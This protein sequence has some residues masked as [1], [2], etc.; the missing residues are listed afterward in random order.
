MNHP[1][2]NAIRIVLETQCGCRR[3]VEWVPPLPVRIEVPLLRPITPALKSEPD[4]LSTP[5]LPVRIFEA[6]GMAEGLPRYRETG[7]GLAD[8]PE[9]PRLLREEWADAVSRFMALQNATF[10]EDWAKVR[11]DFH[12]R[13]DGASMVMHSSGALIGAFYPAPQWESAEEAL[14]LFR[15]LAK[16]GDQ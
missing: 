12:R 7:L 8:L 5:R 9:A 6:H 1:E 14:S 15:L 10:R 2:R 3:T 4:P 16:G 11:E 13:H